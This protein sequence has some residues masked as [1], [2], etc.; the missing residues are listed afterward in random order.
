MK[1]KGKFVTFEGGDGSGKS[2]Q[3]RLLYESLRSKDIPVILT[4]EPGGSEGAE[5]IRDIIVKGSVNKVDPYTELL[6]LVAARRDHILKT[7]QPALGLGKWVICD[8]FIDS[9]LVYQGGAKGVAV[10]LIQDLHKT[11]CFEMMPDKTVLCDISVDNGLGRAKARSSEEDRFEQ[12]G[13]DFHQNVRDGFLS[14][15]QLYPER[16][17]VI[18]AENSIENIHFQIVSAMGFKLA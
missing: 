18:N 5:E 11:F 1:S 2:T 13:Y 4:R 12:S 14:L 7:I 16:Y 17:L 8:R 6:L 3:A 9:T 15:S 10:E